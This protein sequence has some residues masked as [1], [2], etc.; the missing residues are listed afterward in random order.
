M[1]L[2]TLCYLLG[3][4]ILISCSSNNESRQKSEIE[5]LELKEYYASLMK[6]AQIWASD[7]YLYEVDIEIGAKKPWAL[8]AGF[9]SPS[10]DYESFEVL[11][12]LQNRYSS[13]VFSHQRKILQQE[14]I[15]PSLWK[16]DSQEALNILLLE[17]EDSI[18]N[19]TELCGS[20]KL[21]RRPTLPKRPLVWWLTYYECGSPAGN[22]SYLDPI[23]GKIIVP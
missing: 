17:N 8:S 18:N 3:V 7:A 2:K 1:K 20:L 22:Y 23:T 5:I 10:K 6:E 15:L 13:R 4:L 14:P 16:I 21:D 12:N 11:L 19:I 9:Y